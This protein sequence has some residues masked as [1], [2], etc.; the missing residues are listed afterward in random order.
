M[1]RLSF[2]S[3][4]ESCKGNSSYRDALSEV[5]DPFFS[6]LQQ[7]QDTWLSSWERDKS[8]F[9][10]GRSQA[11]KAQEAILAWWVILHSP[12]CTVV[13][14]QCWIWMALAE[15]RSQVEQEHEWQCCRVQS[16]AEQPYCGQSS[17]I[18]GNKGGRGSAAPGSITPGKV[19]PLRQKHHFER[20][21]VWCRCLNIKNE[22][23]AWNLT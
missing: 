21:V 7:I 15:A 5:I 8:V 14:L 23:V 2:D 19:P 9:L 12:S 1:K 6:R 18:L 20:G 16:R 11:S 3:I 17:P 13:S 22:H 10:G 4:M